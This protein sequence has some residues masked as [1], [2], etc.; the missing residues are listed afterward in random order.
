VRDSQL[1]A[2]HGEPLGSRVDHR[3]LAAAQLRKQRAGDADRPAAR[4]HDASTRP[5]IGAPHR[6]RTDRQE[7]DHRGLVQRDAAG[8]KHES[9]RN[10]DVLRHAA[11]SVH[12]QNRDGRAAVRPALAAGAAFTARNVRHDIDRLSGLQRRAFRRLDHFTRK[13]VTHHARIREVWLDTAKDVHVSAAYTD[14]PHAHEHVAG[15][16]HWDGSLLDDEGAGP[17]ANYYIHQGVVHGSTYS[18]YE[19]R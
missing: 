1:V 3:Y 10:A 11:V 12:A 13:L 6:M 17:R 9:L 15:T 7:F 16:R 2:T 18:A 4:H 8:G 19:S 14:P 5:D